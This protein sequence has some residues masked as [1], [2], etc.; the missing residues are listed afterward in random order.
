MKKTRN[1]TSMFD[2]CREFIVQK[3]DEG[4][5]IKEVFNL[6]NQEH[7]FYDY[8]SFYSYVHKKLGYVRTKAC[9]E[10]CGNILWVH[11]PTMRKERPVCIAR[12][13]IM[14]TDFKDKPYKCLYYV[15]EQE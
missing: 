4:Y 14:R 7:G 1:R 8:S 2:E 10:K 5:Q 11:C 3:L 9:C 15:A 6:L 12:R 13:K